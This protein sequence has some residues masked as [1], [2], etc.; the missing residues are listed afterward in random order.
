MPQ[1]SCGLLLYSRLS[2]VLALA[3][4]LF[5]LPCAAQQPKVLAPHK[6]VPPVISPPQPLHKPA[7]PRSLLGRL[8]MTDASMKSYLHITNDLVTSSLAVT[9]IIWLS[10]GTKLTLPPINLE[11]SGTAVIN[12]NQALADQGLAP[13]ATLS[14]Y[15][16]LDYQWPWDALCATVRN[17]DFAHSV[18]FA[19]GLQL[20][21]PSIHTAQTTTQVTQQV[22]ESLWWKQEA[23][24]T[25][26]VAFTNPGSETIPA[27]LTVIDAQ[28]NSMSQNSVTVSPHGQK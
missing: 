15:V 6:P 22:L 27:N 21:S 28:G 9:P 26:F 24:V 12:I 8:W 18:I 7:V 14:G 23:N 2:S 10:N 4:V 20:T 11:P 13:Y 17:V 1:T 3:F 25:G 5:A 19:S 16:E